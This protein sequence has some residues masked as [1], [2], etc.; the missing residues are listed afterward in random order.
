MRFWAATLLCGA[1]G[2]AQI[3]GLDTTTG[4]ADANVDRTSLQLTRVSVGAGVVRNPLDLSMAT[5]TFYA[6]DGAGGYT[7]VAGVNG[8]V[9]T[10]TAAINTGTPPVRF[11]TPDMATHFWALPAR[12]Q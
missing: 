10:F 2:C 9:D 6:D 4:G 3:F 12:A 5:A 7:E 1:T 8:P 11:T